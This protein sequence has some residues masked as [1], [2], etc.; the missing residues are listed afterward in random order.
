[1][2]KQSKRDQRIRNAYRMFDGQEPD[3]STERL[4][5]QVADFC[6]CDTCRV[7]EALM[8]LGDLKKSERTAP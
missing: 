6:N 7:V 2:S 3:I 4:L 1:M 8:R 5:Q